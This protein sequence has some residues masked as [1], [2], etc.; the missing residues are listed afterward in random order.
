M[1]AIGSARSLRTPTSPSSSCD[2]FTP[3]GR[4]HRTIGIPPR[5]GSLRRRPMLRDRGRYAPALRVEAAGGVA[6]PPLSDCRQGDDA[7]R[8]R[9]SLR[10]PLLLPAGRRRRRAA[11]H[12]P[13]AKPRHMS[14]HAAPRPTPDGMPGHPNPPCGPL[15][16][17]RSVSPVP[18]TG[19]APP[20]TRPAAVRS[21]VLISRPPRSERSGT[22]SGGHRAH[23]V[24]DRPSSIFRMGKRRSRACRLPGAAAPRPLGSESPVVYRDRIGET[25]RV[26]TIPPVGGSVR[27][28]CGSTMR[29]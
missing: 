22:S 6:R 14:R 13:P 19:S 28:R 1:S 29:S 12:R 25:C 11:R 5:A 4:G 23:R 24:I 3:R 9:D 20:L 16:I 17:P 21:P 8:E 10:S 26:P 2:P 27:R 7:S 18:P 15:A